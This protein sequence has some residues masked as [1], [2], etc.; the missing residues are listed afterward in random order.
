MCNVLKKFFIF[1]WVV[2]KKITFI[3]WTHTSNLSKNKYLDTSR[4]KVP[5]D[6]CIYMYLYA[7]TLDL[8]AIYESHFSCSII[9]HQSSIINHRHHN[10]HHHHN[11][12]WVL[13]I[14]LG[15]VTLAHWRVAGDRPHLYQDQTD[16]EK[17]LFKVADGNECIFK[18]PPF[19]GT[20]DHG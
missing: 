2:R 18:W 19:L 8:F 14:I 16:H 12:L 20:G 10:N 15:L 5:Q 7:A 17:T 3:N 9:N 13:L 1:Q 6:W 4:E 11:P